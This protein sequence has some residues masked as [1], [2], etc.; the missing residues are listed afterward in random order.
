M[1]PTAAARPEARRL[2]AAEQRGMEQV[3]VIRLAHL[4]PEHV[5]AYRIADNRLTELGGCDHGLLR[6]ELEA[7]RAADP[8]PATRGD[9]S[10]QR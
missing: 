10:G 2:P 9:A 7:L 3:P 4:A 1:D 8:V 6:A 5:K